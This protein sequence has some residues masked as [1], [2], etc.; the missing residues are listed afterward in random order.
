MVT[1]GDVVLARTVKQVML[2]EAP[3]ATQWDKASTIDIHAKRIFSIDVC[4][5]ANTCFVINGRALATLR[6]KGKACVVE[7]RLAIA[8]RPPE[9]EIAAGQLLVAM[10]T[11]ADFL[12]R[13]SRESH[14]LL[15]AD[16]TNP[17]L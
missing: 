13:L 9:M 16:S 7:I 5:F 12:F 1:H 2:I 14:F 4:H 8:I 15:K 3:V 6:G 10:R 17:T 11:E